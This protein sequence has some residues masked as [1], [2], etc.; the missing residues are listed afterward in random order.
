MVSSRSRIAS[1]GRIGLVLARQ[2]DA[3]LARDAFYRGRAIAARLR[4]QFPDDVQ[5]PKQLA[6]FDE[7][8]ATIISTP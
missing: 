2:A 1:Y 7:Q 4:E 8:I 3:T 5:L 6:A